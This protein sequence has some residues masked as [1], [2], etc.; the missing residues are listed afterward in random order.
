LSDLNARFDANMARVVQ[1]K[2][3]KARLG[4]PKP[5]RYAAIT[6]IVLASTLL[7]ILGG[8]GLTVVIGE[9]LDGPPDL[10]L[11]AVALATLAGSFALRFRR[12]RAT[13]LALLVIGLAGLGRGIAG[14][15]ATG[16]VG[17]LVLLGLLV[18]LASVLGIK[19][20]FRLAALKDAKGSL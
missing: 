13:A 4:K 6:D 7:I 20:A 1:E 8:I 12:D 14:T 18:A 3:L 2:Q 15:M 9:A 5:G 17:L 11:G 19:G 16:H 10:A